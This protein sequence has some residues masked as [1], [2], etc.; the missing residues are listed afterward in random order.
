MSIVRD[1]DDRIRFLLMLRHLNDRFYSPNWFRDVALLKSRST[2]SLFIRP[3]S[4][5]PQ[6][7]IVK[8]ICFCLVENHFH[9]LLEEITDGGISL[10]M[11]RLS[12]AM[13]KH[14]NEKYKETG[15]LFQGAYRSR[16]VS[17][18]TYLRYVSS[19]IQVK[20]CFE[21]FPAGYEKAVNSF[22]Q[23]FLWA[24]E[25]PY[26]SLNA[27]YSGGTKADYLIVNTE[28]LSGMFTEDTYKVFCRDFVSGRS[29]KPHTDISLE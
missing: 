14:F 29:K 11:Q 25:Y 20:N 4:W 27:Y 7:K 10:F 26:S 9:L 23:T 16:T 21:V 15:S 6:E 3:D 24:T 5:P 12:I 18:D 22:D 1:E 28:L 8:I 2:D 17:D 19:Y 13:A